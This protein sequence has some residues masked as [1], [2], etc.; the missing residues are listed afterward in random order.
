MPAPSGDD[1]IDLARQRAIDFASDHSRWTLLSEIYRGKHK[2][3]FPLEFRPDESAKIA[4]F[5][6]RSWKMFA[7]LVGK[8]PDV[9]VAPLSERKNQKA[10]AEKLEK[11]CFAYHLSW[12]MKRKMKSFATFYVGLG[13]AGIG[14]VPDPRSESPMLLIE[15]PRN[16]LPG[17]G[18]DSASTAGAAFYPMV[19]SPFKGRAD[20][21]GTLEDCII[22]KTLTGYQLRKMFPNSAR[23]AELVPDTK[24]AERY[25]QFNLLQFY[26]SEYWVSVLADDGTVLA[27]DEHRI[28]WCPWQFPCTFAPD[29]PAGDSD[30]EQQIGL[31]VAFMRILDQKLSLNDAVTWPWVFEKGFVRHFP[32]KRLMVA[33]SPDAEVSF[34]TPPPE[35][36]VDRDMQLLQGLIRTLNWETEASQ[37]Q[38][39]GGPITGRGIV[40]L[41]RPTV[42]TV[43]DFFDDFTF[44][45]PRAHTTA[46]LIDREWFSGVEKDLAGRG[47]GEP[48][49]ESYTPGK[50]IPDRFGMVQVEF[51]PGL[52]GY[53]DHLQMLQDLGP[54]AIAVETVMSKNPH[55]RSVEEEKR[56]VW[57]EKIDKV[58]QGQALTG[59]T[60]V[61]FEWLGRFRQALQS[62]QDPGEWIVA[63]PPV[64]PPA[65]LPPLPPGMG[66]PS[67][68]P[69]GGGGEPLGLPAGPGAAPGGEMSLAD[70]LGVGGA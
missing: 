64:A 66:P 10:K 16:V 42:E 23:L 25:S 15:D 1:V 27:S 7:K 34:L 17:A 62:G 14:V 6:R 63:N 29:Q 50:D 67:G 22:R 58:L 19:N 38:V 31:E 69:P 54:E 41:S 51:G 61:P 46:L 45:L 18:W 40:E 33:G 24:A 28:G 26:D 30:F 36:Q 5:I 59:E 9:Y 21:G 52:G 65:E 60:V 48:F 8:V 39:K 57:I 3:L 32:D 13:A 4:G 53:E 56:K 55:I 43:Q 70:I 37:G 20:S 12:A 44:Y 68:L 2:T 49:L 47:H 11:I 35:F